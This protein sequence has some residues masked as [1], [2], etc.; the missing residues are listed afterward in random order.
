MAIHMDGDDSIYYLQSPWV[1]ENRDEVGTFINGYDFSIPHQLDDYKFRVANVFQN[2]GD[3]HV[4]EE[5]NFDGFEQYEGY[6]LKRG[7]T[8][9]RSDY[10]LVIYYGTEERP[11]SLWINNGIRELDLKKIR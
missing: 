1:I 9:D 11:I 5:T 8:S 10:D 2:I 6:Q 3:E 4:D 7:Y